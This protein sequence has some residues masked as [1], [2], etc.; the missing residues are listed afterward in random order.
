[1]LTISADSNSKQGI[2][3]CVV[4]LLQIFKADENMLIRAQLKMNVKTKTSSRFFFFSVLDTDTM[5]SC[6]VRRIV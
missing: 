4:Y 1:M 2:Q 6:V 3:L 5:Y